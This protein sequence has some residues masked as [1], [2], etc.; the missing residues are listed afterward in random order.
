LV[1]VE[2]LPAFLAGIFIG[3]HGLSW[4]VQSGRQCQQI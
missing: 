3:R 1:S 2:I 4:L